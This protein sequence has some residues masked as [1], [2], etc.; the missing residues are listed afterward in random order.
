MMNTRCWYVENSLLSFRVEYNEYKV[1]CFFFFN[2]KNNVFQCDKTSIFITIPGCKYI[3]FTIPPS[4]SQV[5]AFE[6][7]SI[8]NFSKSRI[9]TKKKKNLL[10]RGRRRCIKK[11]KKT[12]NPV[13]LRFKRFNTRAIR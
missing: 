13:K 6:F 2:K 7:Y 8:F 11:K 1:G 10:F 12:E 3:R 5:Y 9:K 4:P